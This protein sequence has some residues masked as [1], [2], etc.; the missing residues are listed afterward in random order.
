MIA[1]K[2]A[3]VAATFAFLFL[4]ATVVGASSNGSGMG[5]AISHTAEVLQTANQSAYLIFYPNLTGAYADYYEA[6]NLSRNTSDHARAYALLNSSERIAASEE[7]RM[8]SYADYSLAALA[9]A[10]IAVG[11]VLYRLMIEESN[12][13][14]R[15]GEK[16]N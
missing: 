11:A 2:V 9:I 5:A 4:Y 13:E 6:V 12:V 15:I 14:M 3:A 7:V 16:R 8:Q 1:M 10:G